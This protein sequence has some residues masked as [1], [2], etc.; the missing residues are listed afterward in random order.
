MRSVAMIEHRSFQLA[1]PKGPV[2]RRVHASG[3]SGFLR[4]RR[5][6]MDMQN[7]PPRRIPKYHP[8][9]GKG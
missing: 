5:P 3:D 6:L 2:D 1:R 8:E 4:H 9:M 7:V